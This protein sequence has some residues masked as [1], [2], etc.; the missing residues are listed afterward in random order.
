MPTQGL[1]PIFQTLVDK[2]IISYL[3]SLHIIY[4]VPKTP[5]DFANSGIR[6]VS[7][8]GIRRDGKVYPRQKGV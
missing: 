5:S 1:S 2:P 3:N 6:H 7:V 8:H 4:I